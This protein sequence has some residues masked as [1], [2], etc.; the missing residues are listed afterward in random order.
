MYD[1]SNYGKSH[2][3]CF[4]KEN[5]LITLLKEQ[6][7]LP[8]WVIELKKNLESE[9]FQEKVF[10]K[11]KTMDSWKKKLLNDKKYLILGK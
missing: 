11:N 3:R 6:D 1:N 4:V 9:L 7:K 8:K 2:T 10:E 5:N